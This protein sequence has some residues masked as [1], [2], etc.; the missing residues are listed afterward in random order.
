M[1]AIRGG[2]GFG[3]PEVNVFVPIRLNQVSNMVQNTSA[4]NKCRRR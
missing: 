1:S 2:A 3:S 4:L